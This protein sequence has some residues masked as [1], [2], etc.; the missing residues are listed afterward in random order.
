MGAKAANAEHPCAAGIYTSPF[1]LPLVAHL[2]D[3]FGALDNL[4]NFVS[5]FGRAFYQQPI[6][7]EDEIVVL[8]RCATGFPVPKVLSESQGIEIIPFM[9]SQRLGWEIV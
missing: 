8:K 7:S 4:E 6:T 9:C 5:T 1:L 2:L 3:S